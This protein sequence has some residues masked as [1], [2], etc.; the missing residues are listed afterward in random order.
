MFRIGHGY[1]V[2]RLVEKRKL[3]LCGQNIKYD[4]GLL[5]H[6][7]ADVATHA[8]IDAICGAASFGDIGRLFPDTD[9]KYRGISSLK[10]LEV[11]EK[12]GYDIKIVEGSK[13]NIKITTIDDLKY[14]EFLAEIEAKNLKGE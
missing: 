3:T 14:A 7:D 11:V 4:K 12:A 6:S 8:L 9:E 10:L 1:D 13:N 5:G 2:H